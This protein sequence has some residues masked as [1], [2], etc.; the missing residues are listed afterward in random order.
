MRINSEEL[1]KELVKGVFL[2]IGYD[3]IVYVCEKL[4]EPKEK[5]IG[6]LESYIKTLLYN[7]HTTEGEYW[8]HKINYDFY[9]GGADE[10]RR[11]MDEGRS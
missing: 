3:E 2:K 10:R 5:P 6:N 4:D 8:T 9:G 1:P 7:A 11:K